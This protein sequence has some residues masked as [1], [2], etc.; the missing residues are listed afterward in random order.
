MKQAQS[1]WFQISGQ[2]GKAVALPSGWPRLLTSPAFIGS[3]PAANT[4]GIVEVACSAANPEGSPPS[5]AM[6]ATPRCTR[7]LANAGR[8]LYSPR[9][10]RYSTVKFLPSV[11]PRLKTA[12]KGLKLK[13]GSYVCLAVRDTGIGMDEHTLRRAIEP[14]FTTKGVGRG[15]GSGYLQCRVLPSNQVVVFNWIASLEKVRLLLSGCPP[16]KKLQWR[17]PLVSNLKFWAQKRKTRPF[18]WLMMRTCARRH[19]RHVG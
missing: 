11:K 16:R 6:T 18:F 3:P 1:L 12:A 13:S 10:H 4:I 17:R 8:R 5:A 14:F 15:T 7:S 2:Q 19:S 9:A